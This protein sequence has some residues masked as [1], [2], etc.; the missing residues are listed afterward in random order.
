MVAEMKCAFL[1]ISLAKHNFP[2]E[3][4]LAPQDGAGL[5]ASQAAGT[6]SVRVSD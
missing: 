6:R 1:E 5:P 4:K 2:H 3:E